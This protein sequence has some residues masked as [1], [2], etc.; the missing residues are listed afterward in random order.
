MESGNGGLNQLAQVMAE[1]DG[2]YFKPD[3]SGFANL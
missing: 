1:G 3:T 2:E